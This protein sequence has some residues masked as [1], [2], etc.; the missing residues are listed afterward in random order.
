VAEGAAVH[1]ADRPTRKKFKNIKKYQKKKYN[2]L[3]KYPKGP[4]GSSTQAPAVLIRPWH[5]YRVGQIK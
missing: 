4:L 3:G 5:I 1:Q 2:W